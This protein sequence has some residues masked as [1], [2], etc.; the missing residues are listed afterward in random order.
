MTPEQQQLLIKEVQAA[1]VLCR[2]RISEAPGRHYKENQVAILK[3]ETEHERQLLLQLER[4]LC[5]GTG[6]P[7]ESNWTRLRKPEVG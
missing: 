4:V 1:L 7:D 3:T 5:G 2:Q 6:S